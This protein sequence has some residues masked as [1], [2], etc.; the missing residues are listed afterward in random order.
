MNLDLQSSK[1][2]DVDHIWYDLYDETMYF[3]KKTTMHH[4]SMS[5]MTWPFVQDS[6]ESR[7]IANAWEV[8]ANL[9]M[10]GGYYG[11]ADVESVEIVNAFYN[12]T[13]ELLALVENLWWL[14]K[15]GWHQHWGSVN[16][17]TEMG[18]GETRDYWTND[19]WRKYPTRSTQPNYVVKR[20]VI[21]GIND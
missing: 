12:K 14:R 8:P 13:K 6:P 4:I 2:L 18:N 7:R 11:L 1:A 3:Q 5:G 16:D 17:G 9:K 10:E 19:Q 15:S 21:S 20:P